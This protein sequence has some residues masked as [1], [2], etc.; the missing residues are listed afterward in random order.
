VQTAL[1]AALK[2]EPFDPSQTVAWAAQAEREVEQLVD[3][4][5]VLSRVGQ[6]PA[7]GAPL[8]EEWGQ[9]HS[10]AERRLSRA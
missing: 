2:L 1:S 8:I 6:I 4:V 10:H 3:R 9:R 7:Y 5:A